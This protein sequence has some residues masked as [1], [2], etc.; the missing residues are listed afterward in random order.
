M[1]RPPGPPNSSVRL[2][3][4]LGSPDHPTD[5]VQDHA[6]A[7]SSA[8]EGLGHRTSIVRCRWDRDGWVRG[9]RAIRG[10]LRDA[11]VV[12]L[13]H[14]NLGWSRRGFP[15]GSVA[16]AAVVGRRRLWVLLHDPL[17]FPAV[18]I[19]GRIRGAVQVGVMRALCRA[20]ARCYS[21]IDPSILRWARRGTAR[22]I[23][24]LPVGSNVGAS[25][26]EPLRPE[27]GP[28]RVAI[29]SITEGSRDERS[30]WF[31]W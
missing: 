30:R 6:E 18:G 7:L 24:I 25:S 19:V 31:G 8:L 10:R 16:A 23:T 5:G 29:F 27:A 17:P 20:G 21:T 22:R 11:D 12:L 4:L 9:L 15:F 13:H 14:T 28:F 26:D 1:T 2:V 3:H